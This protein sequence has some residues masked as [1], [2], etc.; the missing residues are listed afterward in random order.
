MANGWL[1][2]FWARGILCGNSRQYSGRSSGAYTEEKKES[3][4]EKTEDGSL[5]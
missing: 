4:K 5:L 3:Q 2:L 1:K